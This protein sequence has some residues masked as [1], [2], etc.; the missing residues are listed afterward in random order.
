MGLLYLSYQVILR[1][2]WVGLLYQSY[3]VILRGGGGGFTLPIISSD[4]EGRRGGFALPI[5]SSDP[6]GEGQVHRQG[7]AMGVNAPPPWAEKVCLERTQDKR[8]ECQ[9]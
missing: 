2:G 8:K 1:G 9:R 7:G 5:I 4:P 6:E 3:Q